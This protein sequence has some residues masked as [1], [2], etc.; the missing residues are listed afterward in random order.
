MYTDYYDIAIVYVCDRLVFHGLCSS[1]G[2]GRVAVFTRVPI[3]SEERRGSME[4][5][6]R[7][8]GYAG[9][10]GFIQKSGFDSSELRTIV[11]RRE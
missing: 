8:R 6:L 7:Y 1:D 9:V 5:Q 10:A 4:D 2:N 3:L 11:H